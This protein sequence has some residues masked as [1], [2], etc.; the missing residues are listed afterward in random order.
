M[1]VTLKMTKELQANPC[2]FLDCAQTWTT[3]RKYSLKLVKMSG[4]KRGTVS[5][6]CS[7]T[8]GARLRCSSTWGGGGLEGV[9]GRR[10]RDGGEMREDG[11]GRCIP[12]RKDAGRPNGDN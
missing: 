5:S 3:V 10:G 11:G 4:P 7:P 9:G 8:V 6:L 1:T 2:Q 12:C